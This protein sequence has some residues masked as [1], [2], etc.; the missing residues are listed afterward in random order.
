MCHEG[1]FRK[2]GNISRQRELREKLDTNADLSIDDQTYTA[3]DC[4]SVLKT[5][6]GELPEPL[7]S[8]RMF[9]AYLYTLGIHILI[10]LL[11]IW[12]SNL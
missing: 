12:Y 11:Y 4:A 7:L 2:T 10:H 6:L 1:L 8:E 9:D 5:V 3:H